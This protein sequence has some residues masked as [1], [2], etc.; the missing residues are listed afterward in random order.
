MSEE[1]IHHKPRPTGNLTSAVITSVLAGRKPG[2]FVDIQKVVDMEIASSQH[3]EA[4]IGRMSCV[5][6]NGEIDRCDPYRCEYGFCGDR[7]RCSELLSGSEPL[8]PP[9]AQIRIFLPEEYERIT[10]G[11]F[12]RNN[13]REALIY[14]ALGSLGAEDDGLG[15]YDPNE[16]NDLGLYYGWENDVE[17]IAGDIMHFYGIE[18][19][20]NLRDNLISEGELPEPLVVKHRL[21]HGGRLKFLIEDTEQRTRFLTWMWLVN[22]SETILRDI[23][24]ELFANSISEFYRDF[25]DNPGDLAA[26]DLADWDIQRFYEG[27][28]RRPAILR[29]Y[30]DF[31]GR[32]FY[33]YLHIAGLSYDTKHNV[34]DQSEQLDPFRKCLIDLH[35]DGRLTPR[36]AEVLL[37]DPRSPLFINSKNYTTNYRGGEFVPLNGRAYSGDFDGLVRK[38]GI[39]PSH[40]GIPEHIKLPSSRVGRLMKV[41]WPYVGTDYLVKKD[42]GLV[43]LETNRVPG[44]QW[45]MVPGATPEMSKLQLHSLLIQNLAQNL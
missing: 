7:T 13:L 18:T 10:M 28:N 26:V 34:L 27:P 37:V 33:S 41:H 2:S 45:Y 14:R 38:L 39:D 1:F 21:S 9:R 40:L 5:G 15:Q 12:N 20:D 25:K 30:S 3:T 16:P 36:T 23:P 44:I 42:G 32:N 35:T 24:E 8:K 6:S 4:V 22:N 29:V 43:F 31:R 19:A 11:A 17:M